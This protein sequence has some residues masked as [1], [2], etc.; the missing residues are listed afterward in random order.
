[1]SETAAREVDVA[2]VGAGPAGAAAAIAFSRRGMSVVMLERSLFPRDK[3]CGDFLTPG[4]VARLRELG[5]GAVEAASPWTLRGMRI[6]F[7]GRD[8]LSDFPPARDGWSLS[9]RSLDAALA[10]RA[11]AAGAELVERIRVDRFGLE[12]DGARWVEASHPD[13]TRQRWRARLLVEAGGRH[14]PIARRVGWRVDDRHLRRFALWSQMEG[15]RGLSER[16]EMHVFE[17]GYVGVAPLAP[18]DGESAAANVTMVLTPERMA[19]ARGD[20]GGYFLDVLRRHPEL[21]RRLAAAR[22]LAPVRGLGPL[23]CSARRLGGR[24]LALVGD[25]C[26]FVDPFTG[27]G[28]FMALE[29]GRLLAEA[30][31]G[32]PAAADALDRALDQYERSWRAAFT[33][34]YRLCRLLQVVIARPWLARHVARALGS[35]KDLA[36][37]MV[38]ATGDLLP[39]S[40]VLN[41]SYLGRVLLAGMTG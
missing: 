19:R 7:E 40:S 3:I 35:H 15:V 13:G 10:R 27:E 36:D 1:V 41:P 11:V 23:A 34:K 29:S 39:A 31:S 22:L 25:A 32:P 16:G 30:V 38:G 2:I 33:S 17:G 5:E 6:T 37:R 20:A 14:G 24:G 12:R 9:R 21:G 8:V 18:G 28:V 4:A 26:G